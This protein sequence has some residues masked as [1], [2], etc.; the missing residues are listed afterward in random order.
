VD[1]RYAEYGQRCVADELLDD[2]PVPLDDRPDRLEMAR[3]HGTNGF[4]VETFSQGRRSHEV[5]EHDRD[6]PARLAFRGS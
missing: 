3:K 6:R 4:G 1:L 2:A 5:A